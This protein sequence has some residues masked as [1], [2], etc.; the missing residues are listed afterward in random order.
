[1]TNKETNLTNEEL[2]DI[3]KRPSLSSVFDKIVSVPD[4]KARLRSNQKNLKEAIEDVRKY[5]NASVKLT[6]I[7]E[8]GYTKEEVIKFLE[9]Y[10]E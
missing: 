3:L 7:L 6:P 2:I 10:L 9:S 5:D 4:W 1:M 8:A